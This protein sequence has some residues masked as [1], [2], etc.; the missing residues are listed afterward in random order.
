VHY[1]QQRM[2]RVRNGQVH[3]LNNLYQGPQKSHYTEVYYFG[4]ALGLGYNSKIYS[5]GNSFEITG[6]S[7]VSL[8]SAD[9]DAWAQYFTDVGS[10]LLGEPVDLNAAAA[11][12]INARNAANG[13]A[14]PFIGPVLWKPA[15]H[16]AYSADASAETVKQKVLARSGVGRVP[17]DPTL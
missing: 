9:F 7:A 15:D 4:Y 14:T 1:V 10:W 5:E 6:A 12:V 2:P 8:L 11:T 13:G 17:P 3:V 16:Y